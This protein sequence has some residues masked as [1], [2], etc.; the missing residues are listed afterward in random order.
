MNRYVLYGTLFILIIIS[1]SK[2]FQEDGDS[3]NIRRANG[4]VLI[5]DNTGKEWNITHAIENYGM[6]AERFQFGLG[7]NAIRPILNPKFIGPN[8]PGFPSASDNRLVIGF[9]LDGDIRAY[10][11]DVLTRH[12]IADDSFGKTKVA[13]AY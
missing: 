3:P 1:C 11:I 12:E 5:I 13:V 2:I 6:K 8:D 4:Q 9:N 7:P 10:P